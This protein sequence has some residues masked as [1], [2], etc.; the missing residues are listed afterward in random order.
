MIRNSG[1]TGI[2]EARRVLPVL[3][4]YTASSMALAATPPYKIIKH[5]SLETKTEEPTFVALSHPRL[6]DRGRL[7]KLGRPF[8]NRSSWF[9]LDLATLETT[10]IQVPEIPGPWVPKPEEFVIDEPAYYDTDLG[11]AGLVLRE[12]GKVSGGAAWAE[13]DLKT[14]RIVNRLTLAPANPK[15][16][17]GV[18]AF[19]FDPSRKETFIQLHTP[20]PGKQEKP[21]QQAGPYDLTILAVTDRVRTVANFK[22]TL[23]Y[24]GKSPYFDPIHRRSMHIEYAECEGEETTA[25]LVNLDSGAVK[26][27]PLPKIIYGFAFHPD[28]RS[29]FAYTEPTGEVFTLDLETGKIGKKRPFGRRAHLLSWIGPNL[30]CLGRNKGMHFIDPTTLK[31]TGFIDPVKFHTKG[32]THLEGST[33]VPGRAIVRIFKNLYILDF[34]T[35][36]P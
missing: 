18:E 24:T 16:W 21:C 32:S 12:G 28:G 9:S 33:F 4:L 22:T 20:S 10:L 15:A 8:G 2:A 11:S 35:L 34:P 27:F 5:I 3:L 29:A 26:K 1:R 17:T 30:L 31:Q 13:W 23:R 25:Y 19:G 6:L 14:N 36:K 7:L